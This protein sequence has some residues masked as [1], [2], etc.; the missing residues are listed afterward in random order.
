MHTLILVF[1]TPLNP[2]IHEPN[3]DGGSQ[4]AIPPDKKRDR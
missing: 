3:P 2:V 1:L 4:K